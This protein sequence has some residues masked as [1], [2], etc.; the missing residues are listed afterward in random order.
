[1]LKIQ[2]LADK[3]WRIKDLTSKIKKIQILQDF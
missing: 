3:I 2:G 1:M